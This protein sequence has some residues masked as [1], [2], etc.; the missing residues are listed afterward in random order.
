MKQKN[1]ELDSEIINEESDEEDES[2]Y[3]VQPH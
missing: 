1:Y 3:K 2:E